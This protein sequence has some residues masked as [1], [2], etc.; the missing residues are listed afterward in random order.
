MIILIQKFAI[1]THFKSNRSVRINDIALYYVIYETFFS[2]WTQNGW[3]VEYNYLDMVSFDTENGH[4]INW[5]FQTSFHA[6]LQNSNS[7]KKLFQT[8][9]FFWYLVCIIFN[10]ILVHVSYCNMWAFSRVAISRFDNLN[11]FAKTHS[12]SMPYSTQ[13]G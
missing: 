13:H 8:F 12:T 7:K 2:L 10:V 5:I 11:Y 6:S 9:I 1:R 3:L 4:L